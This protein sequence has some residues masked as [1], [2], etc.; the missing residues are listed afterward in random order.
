MLKVDQEK[1]EF[2]IAQEEELQSDIL[3][4]LL[5]VMKELRVPK[6]EAREFLNVLSEVAMLAYKE[7]IYG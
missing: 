2:S 5:F 7:E 3:T 4:A 1:V 6:E